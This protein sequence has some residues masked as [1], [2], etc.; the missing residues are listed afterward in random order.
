MVSSPIRIHN[1]S[2]SVPGPPVKSPF[3]FISKNSGSYPIVTLAEIAPFLERHYD[4]AKL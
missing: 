2:P 1:I 4:L 3:R